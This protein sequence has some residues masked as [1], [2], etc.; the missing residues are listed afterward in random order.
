MRH[1][2]LWCHFRPRTLAQ[3]PAAHAFWALKG[4][5]EDDLRACG[6]Q[7]WGA[8]GSWGSG[9][10]MHVKDPYDAN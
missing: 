10:R 9:W 1:N 3:R 7:G 5:Q 6:G 2:G 4:P 8:G